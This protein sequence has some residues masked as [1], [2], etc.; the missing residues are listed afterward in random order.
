MTWTCKLCALISTI[1]HCKSQRRAR[2]NR[3]FE[4]TQIERLKI[5]SG[6]RSSWEHCKRPS[7]ARCQDITKRLHKLWLAASLL[8]CS[9]SNTL[10]APLLISLANNL[11]YMLTHI[12]QLGPTATQGTVRSARCLSTI[13]GRPN[14]LLW[15]CLEASEYYDTPSRRETTAQG[16]ILKQA[17]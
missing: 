4:R 12:P 17:T 9:T 8:N 5:T 16:S 13:Q 6:G 14:Q 1:C 11:R 10:A 2:I 15:T 3:G 7:Q